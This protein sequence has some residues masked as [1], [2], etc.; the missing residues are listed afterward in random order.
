MKVE[1]VEVRKGVMGNP[2]YEWKEF[3]NELN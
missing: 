2:I 3:D 1:K